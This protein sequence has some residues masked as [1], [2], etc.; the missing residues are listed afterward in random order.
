MKILK[1]SA[2]SGKTYRLSHTYLDILL[3]S[4][5][6]YAYRHIL[7]VTFTN[8]A[9]A[10][11]KNRILAA[12]YE[13]SATDEKAKRLLV[14][15]LHDYS[16]F[17]V[18]TIDKFFQHVLK[19]FSREIGQF[20]DYQIELDRKSLITESMDRILDSLSE[21]NKDLFEWF[22]LNMTDSLEQGRKP[23][24]DTALYEMGAMLKSE[25]HRELA[26]AV[27]VSDSEMF[28]KEK[29][30]AVR[31][32][33]RRIIKDFTE[34]AEAFGITSR[35]G[36]KVAYPN[37]T[38]MKKA[39]AEVADLFDRP[40]KQYCTMWIVDRL[41]YSLGLAGEFY[42]TFDELLR[43]KNVM[44]LDESN[45][46]L[47]DIIEG[48]DA[49]FVYEKTGTRYDSFLLDEFQDTSRIQWQNFL[50]LLKESESKGGK[51]LIVG[52]VKQSIYRWR[53]S[54]WELLGKRIGEEFPRAEL[55]VLDG[56]WRSCQQVVKF[57][58][59]FFT[60]AAGKLGLSDIYSDVCQKVRSKDEQEGC[61]RLSFCDDQDAATVL[62]VKDA[63]D[64]GAEYG[65]IA[66]LVRNRKEGAHLASILMDND[67][68]VISDD[69]LN[70]KSSVVVSRLV[71]LLSSISD[72]EDSISQYLIS[73]LNVSVPENYHSL[74]DLCEGLLRGLRADD[75]RAFDGELLF[76]QA[77]MDELR[78]W[79]DINGGDLIRFL[80]YWSEKDFYIGSPD[81]ADSVRVLTVH[82]AK[83][84]EFPYLIFPYAD[85]VDMYKHGVHWCRLDTAGTSIDGSASLIYPVDLT[86]SSEQTLFSGDYASERG[87]QL[88]DNMNVFY[89]ALTR[90]RCTLHVIAKQPSATFKKGLSKGTPEYG[91]FSELLYDFGGAFDEISFGSPYDYSRLERKEQSKS[92]NFPGTY[93]S[94]PVGGRL[95]P[96]E[97]AEDFFGEDGLAGIAASPRLNGIVLHDV[98][99]GVREP[100][101][102]DG[103][104]LEAVRSGRLTAEEADGYRKLLTERIAAHPEWFSGDC[105]NEV[106]L[107]GADGSEH[108]P[109][110]VVLSG[111]RTVVIDYK[112]G[113]E[114]RS[115]EKQ[116]RGYM[117]LYRALGYPNVSGA[118]WYV[119]EDR[120]IPVA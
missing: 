29:L 62:S 57:N 24:I 16:A 11:M 100:S 42:K 4:D 118:V 112:F 45:T 36:E 21:E 56:N 87:K 55:E 117:N 59:G 60:F 3:S 32:E 20:A 54:D 35:P 15:I 48:S 13:R 75:E 71:A 102:L 2:G 37:K 44:C 116:V 73:S 39:P 70:V 9:T 5:D 17:S 33:C 18:S 41:I 25:E 77:F 34:K 66:I 119:R 115:Y 19:S 113:E 43:E 78:S 110:R 52:D 95:Q 40:Y 68:P 85:K 10:E 108:R 6:R 96:S 92:E 63:L 81:N 98:L 111:D 80:K 53:N 99:S 49:P 46:I 83:G 82:K 104:V 74:V 91:N 103:A 7:A 47:R 90:A 61:V 101:D 1:A 28:S 58:N 8:K 105:R 107:F 12:L 88:V 50:P 94:I 89:V 69:S 109:D 120:V 93:C 64:S 79:V 84:L 26:E 76:I 65:D 38:F 72:P 23:S 30:K 31:R 27:G 86:R 51:N 97:E 14:D 106:S 67:I 22:R 114:K